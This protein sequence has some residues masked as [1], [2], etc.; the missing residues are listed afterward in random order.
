MEIRPFRISPVHYLNSYN[1]SGPMISF[2]CK[3]GQIIE[4]P[5]DQAG[6]TV[7]CSHCGLLRDIPTLSDLSHLIDD[8]TYEIEPSMQVKEQHRI[9]QVRRAFSKERMDDE[10]DEIDLRP[11]MSDVKRAGYIEEPQD[12]QVPLIPKYDPVTGELVEAIKVQT[13]EVHPSQIPTAQRFISYATAQH[14]SAH[15]SGLKIFLELFQPVNVAVMIFILLA[16]GIWEFFSSL[17]LVYLLFFV[18]LVGVIT[19]LFLAHY[20]IVIEEIAIEE[21]DELPRPLTRI[22]IWAPIFSGPAQT[23]SWRFSFASPRLILL[24]SN[25]TARR[26]R[27]LPPSHWSRSVLSFSRR[28]CSR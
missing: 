2:P 25:S 8:G 22:R 3:C 6:L 10:G 12:D 17:P 20:A 1:L 7:Q 27:R 9:D 5:D 24:G 23:S 13:D 11:T 4:V 14:Q 26:S 21:R 16:H 19:L 18:P 15:H 28:F